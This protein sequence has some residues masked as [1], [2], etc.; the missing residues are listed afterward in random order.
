MLLFRTARKHARKYTRCSCT[1][2]KQRR[3]VGSPCCS[4]TVVVVVVA[5]AVAVST[6]E[7]MH[8]YSG[9]Y[10]RYNMQF[11]PPCHDT[12]QRFSQYCI[13][14]ANQSTAKTR[15]AYRRHRSKS[16]AAEMSGFSS[17]TNRKWTRLDTTWA[18]KQRASSH[19]AASCVIGP[20]ICST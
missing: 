18:I 10:N 14:A 12:R 19:A 6:P 11:V 7:C 20:P 17:W 15:A 1:N 2:P 3:L 16:T 9:A 8:A 4:F 13:A 5:V